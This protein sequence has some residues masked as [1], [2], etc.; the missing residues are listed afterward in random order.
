MLSAQIQETLS[1]ALDNIRK[2]VQHFASGQNSTRDTPRKSN[3]M[4]IDD[5]KDDFAPIRTG[6]TASTPAPSSPLSLN[7]VIT[8]RA[9][10]LFINILLMAQLLQSPEGE[11]F[12]DKST[13]DIVCN[14]VRERLHILLDPFVQHVEE[15]NIR[16]G[17][18]SLERL[19]ENLGKILTKYAFSRSETTHG[20]VLRLLHSSSHMWA[21]ATTDDS[22]V[23]DMVAELLSWLVSTFR[24]GK[25]GSWVTRDLLVQLLDK[26]IQLDHRM[27]FWH[28]I[29]TKDGPLALPDV[30]LAESNQDGDIRVRFRSA[31]ACA[32]LFVGPYILT[33]DAMG[34]YQSIRDNLCLALDK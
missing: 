21:Q 24:E 13:T 22:K 10:P 29:E 28:S 9:M 31:I 7:Q 1:I 17:V 2:S 32:R 4:E 15:K 14:C 16:F 30:V 20:M 34:V 8:D 19:L 12:R 18:S 11:P 33:R 27:G 23:S 25:I 6:A 26:Y 5:D 3:N